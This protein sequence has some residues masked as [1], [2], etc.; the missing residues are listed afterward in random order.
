[1]KDK[2]KNVKNQAIIDFYRDEFKKH[3]QQLIKQKHIY[4]KKT[5]HEINDALSRLI[6]SIDQIYNLDNFEELASELLKK[7]DVVTQLYASIDT[8]NIIH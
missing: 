4:S 5:F 3:Y 2:E 6:A 1:M 8:H 7:I